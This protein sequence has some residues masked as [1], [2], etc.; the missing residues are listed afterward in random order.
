MIYDTVIGLFYYNEKA[1]HIDAYSA[2][3]EDS[4]LGDRGRTDK[5]I[6]IWLYN[7]LKVVDVE[8]LLFVRTLAVWTKMVWQRQSIL[9]T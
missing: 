2:M 3:E 7:R 9:T 4:D 1:Y 8:C 6:G 5:D